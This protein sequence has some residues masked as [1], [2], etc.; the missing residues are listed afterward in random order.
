MLAVV[1]KPLLVLKKPDYLFVLDLIIFDCFI[2]DPYVVGG[3]GKSIETNAFVFIDIF[4]AL[5]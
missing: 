3:K 1:E 4:Y 5:G 2:G